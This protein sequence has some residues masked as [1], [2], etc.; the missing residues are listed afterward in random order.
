MSHGASAIYILDSTGTVLISKDYRDDIDSYYATRFLDK[1]LEQ[2]DETPI[3]DADG[4][5]YTYIRHKELYF[6]SLSIGNSNSA[7]IISFL[8]ELLSVSAV[9]PRKSLDSLFFRFCREISIL[10]QKKVYWTTS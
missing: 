5:T 10:W 8:H 7:M 4:V 1:I 9:T 3:F 6:L 2:D